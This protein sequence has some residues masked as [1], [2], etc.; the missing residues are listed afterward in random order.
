MKVYVLTGHKPPDELGVLAV[1]ATEDSAMKDLL[2]LNEDEKW[3]SGTMNFTVKEATMNDTEIVYCV[4]RRRN[5]KRKLMNIYPTIEAAY[6]YSIE[7]NNS[8]V[9]DGWYYV[10]QRSIINE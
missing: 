8:R 9:Q 3:M 2:Q 5:G 7:L 6:D 10:T 1:Y 4:I